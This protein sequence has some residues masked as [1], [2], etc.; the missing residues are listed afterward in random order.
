MSSAKAFMSPDYLQLV[1]QQRVLELGYSFLFTA[2][3][4][5]TKTRN[6]FDNYL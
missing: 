1:F 3:S 6:F 4:F 5:F 2:R